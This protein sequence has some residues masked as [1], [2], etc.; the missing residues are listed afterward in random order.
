MKLP[1]R[2]AHANQESKKMESKNC[3]FSNIRIGSVYVPE[4]I[5]AMEIFY[6]DL[7]RSWKKCVFNSFLFEQ[8]LS[9]VMFR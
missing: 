6:A 8:W 4:S 2:E 9:T 1:Y 5:R 7:R 3:E